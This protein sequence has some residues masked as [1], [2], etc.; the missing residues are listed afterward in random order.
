MVGDG[1]DSWNEKEI[2]EGIAYIARHPKLHEVI[3]SGG[4]PLILSDK[5]LLML[6]EALKK[7]PHVRRLR[8]DTKVLT[9]LPQRVTEGLAELLQKNQPF[10]VIGH[11]THPSE[12]TEETRE[13]C[14]RLA[15]A[16]VPL[17]AHTPL[18]KGI[19]DDGGSLVELMEDLVDC[20]S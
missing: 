4:D 19:N 18:L 15:D 10:Y 1:T 16:G 7:I 6:T 14:R 12:L 3:L 13:A 8:I 9:M 20:G 5:R 2:Q 17:R 11:F